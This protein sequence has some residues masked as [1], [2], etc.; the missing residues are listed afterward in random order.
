V[1]L[2]YSGNRG[3][4]GT[5]VNSGKASPHQ[6]Q[7]RGSTHAFSTSSS[8]RP[9]HHHNN[10]SNIHEMVDGVEDCSR[11]TTTHYDDDN[12]SSRLDSPCPS[13]ESDPDEARA[14]LPHVSV[15]VKFRHDPYSMKTS[16][17]RT[18]ET[19]MTLP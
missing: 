4:N 3:G 12:K 11:T 19:T 15:H 18:T 1:N 5:A 2:N 17:V 10:S 9:N 14:N 16:Q 8:S 7:Q 6:H 13:L